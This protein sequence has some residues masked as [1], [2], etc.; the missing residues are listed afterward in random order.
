ML[1]TFYTNLS[2]YKDTTEWPEMLNTQFDTNSATQT[3]PSSVN[4]NMHL[5]SPAPFHRMIKFL[6]TIYKIP[7][8]PQ[9]AWISIRQDHFKEAEMSKEIVYWSNKLSQHQ[10]F[11][12]NNK[13]AI[14]QEVAEGNIYLGE[15]LTKDRYLKFK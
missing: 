2:P 6:T 7:N 1:F 11:Q 13:D 8:P 10:A 3:K 4:T 5:F 12:E 14:K 9:I 15:K